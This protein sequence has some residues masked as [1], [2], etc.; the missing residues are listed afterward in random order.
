V[1][2][3]IANAP[4]P[5]CVE[6]LIVAGREIRKLNLGRRNNRVLQ[7]LRI[8]FRVAR[9]VARVERAK[10]RIKLTAQRQHSSDFAVDTVG[11]PILTK[12]DEPA[13]RR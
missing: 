3:R 6:H 8:V 7:Q 4:T 9:A 5:S 13:W 1:A 2:R 12:A 11:S 10:L